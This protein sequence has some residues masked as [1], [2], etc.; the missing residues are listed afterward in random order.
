MAKKKVHF[1]GGRLIFLILAVVV[2]YFVFYG[3]N[4]I[5]NRVIDNKVDMYLAN[6]INLVDL[7][8]QDFKKIETVGRGIKVTIE[9]NKPIKTEDNNIFYE[10]VIDD[11]LYYVPESSLTEKKK[12]VVMEKKIYVRTATNLLKDPKSSEL[13]GLVKKGEEL[14][15]TNYD[16]INTEGIVNMYKVK[17]NN[18]EGYIN[19]KYTVFDKESALANYEPTKYYDVHAKRGNSYGG[20]SAANLDYYPVTK[21]VFVNNKMPDPVYALYLNAG[22][23]VIGNIDSYIA[24]AKDTKINAFVVDIKDN[25]TSGYK[26]EV[27]REYSITSYNKAINS[28]ENYKTAI[29]K[30]KDAGF[31]VIGRITL[32]K[33][34]YYA[35]DHPENTIMDTRTG[36]SYLHS[37][38]YWPSPYKRDVWEYNVELA[39]EAVKEMGF[40]EIQF[41][42][43]RFPDRTG[44]AEKQGVMDF[45]NAYGEEKAQAVQ[46]FLMY[47]TDQLHPLNVYVSADVF[48][49][50]AHTYVTAYGQ[51]WAAISN[52]VDVISGMPYPDHF[53][54]NE[55]GFKVPVWTVPYDLLKYWGKEYVMKRQAEAPTPAI[56]RTWIQAFDTIKAPYIT[57]NAEN[58]EAEIKGLFDAGLNGGYMTWNSGSS[59]AKYRLQLP[60]YSKNYK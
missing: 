57:Y 6:N 44:T 20:G 46:R 39:K 59:I 47:A 8:N 36:E 53:S 30:L 49:E 41:D 34:L 27:M 21:P 2:A 43:V 55:Y 58:V 14:E 29:K 18:E 12:D 37:G 17:Y 13:L 24:L 9:K 40:N 50:S 11:H 23:N 10:V 22:S 16:S 60:A 7:Y 32:F 31:Y 3:I 54:T 38:T 42:Y 52:V 5:L 25:E 56:V 51:Y 48:G 26:S 15:V 45:R 4:Y 35:K 1:K 28:F 19:S 33:D